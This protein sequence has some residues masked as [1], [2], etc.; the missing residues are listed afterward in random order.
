MSEMIILKIG[1]RKYG[2]RK[3]PPLQG[4]AFGLKV[5]SL[6]SKLAAGEGAMESLKGL[7]AK[8]GDGKAKEMSSDSMVTVGA[9][10]ISL[11]SNVNPKELHEILQ[12]A[13]SYEVYAGESKLSDADAFDIHFQKH[14]GDLYVVGAWATYNHVHDFFV[15]LG[16]GLKALMSNSK[17]NPAG[18]V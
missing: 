7:Q 16:D 10:L 6:V 9:S 11:I 14:P 8:F 17:T 1:E 18:Q 4:S 15:G 5:A 3:M 12:E 2:M 13:F